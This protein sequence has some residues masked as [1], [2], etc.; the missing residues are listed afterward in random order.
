MRGSPKVRVFGFAQLP[1]S[2]EGTQLSLLETE[3]TG[4]P[5]EEVRSLHVHLSLLN[6]DAAPADQEP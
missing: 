3:G 1:Q 2:S 4:Y 6:Q 5:D